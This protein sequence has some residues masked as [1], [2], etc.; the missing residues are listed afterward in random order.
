MDRWYAHL[1]EFREVARGGL[2][3]GEDRVAEP[4]G[5]QVAQLALEELHALLQT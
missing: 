4:R 5:A 2:A 1:G 3:N